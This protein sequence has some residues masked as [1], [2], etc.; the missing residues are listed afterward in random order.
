MGQTPEWVLEAADPVNRLNAYTLHSTYTHTALLFGS[1]LL[2]YNIHH[3]LFCL[4]SLDIIVYIIC[5]FYFIS[6]ETLNTVIIIIF[7]I[8]G[9]MC[10]AV[11][12]TTVIYCRV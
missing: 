10:A 9:H 6:V 7:Y 4:Q 12:A 5:C 3:A 11:A 1:F 2:Y 8:A